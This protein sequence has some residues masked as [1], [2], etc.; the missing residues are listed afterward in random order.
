[1]LKP[2]NLQRDRGGS[3]AREERNFT[4]R[5]PFPTVHT[6]NVR[7]AFG[8]GTRAGNQLCRC[9][10]QRLP[11]RGCSDQTTRSRAVVSRST[12]FFRALAAC[13][14]LMRSAQSPGFPPSDHRRVRTQPSWARLRPQE[15]RAPGFYVQ[16]SRP[17][18]QNTMPVPEPNPAIASW[19]EAFSGFPLAISR[20]ATGINA[21]VLMAQWSVVI[22]QVLG[23]IA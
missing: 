10:G 20:E 16:G 7:A 19:S 6:A 1:M 14:D 21:T 11:R 2:C 17:S 13:W 12:P 22:R 18:E 3:D 9:L 15:A 5:P 4:R 8:G 23:L